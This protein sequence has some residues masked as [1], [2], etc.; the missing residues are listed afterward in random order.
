[1]DT[2]VTDLSESCR[3]K[4]FEICAIKLRV[5]ATKL[6]ILC[7]YR[8]PS[9]DFSYFLKQLEWVLNKLHKI[10]TNIILC[11]DFNVNF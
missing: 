2:D 8:S 1:V 6:S 7:T 5:K 9:G 10:S 4:D 11:G 3:E